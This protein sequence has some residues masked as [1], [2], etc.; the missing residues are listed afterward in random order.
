MPPTIK[1]STLSPGTQ[2]HLEAKHR[3]KIF[4]EKKRAREETWKRED[5]E[6]AVK[7]LG[8]ANSK[9]KIKKASGK[10]SKEGDPKKN[11]KSQQEAQQEKPSPIPKKIRVDSRVD[12][13][14]ES[15]K[16]VRD[17]IV[18]T[19]VTDSQVDDVPPP[20]AHA[21]DGSE[22][23]AHTSDSESVD[24]S[25]TAGSEEQTSLKKHRSSNSQVMLLKA[26]DLLDKT[27][28]VSKIETFGNKVSHMKRDDGPLASNFLSENLKSQIIVT[29]LGYEGSQSLH[30]SCRGI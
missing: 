2:E 21:S 28:D 10:T 6:D 24:S 20:D 23:G 13:S 29:L 9:K 17:A 18:E 22:E 5:E 1:T 30:P 16:R 8:L 25:L 27:S 3:A 15:F 4:I 11:P 7:K 19:V 14:K 26:H 12:P